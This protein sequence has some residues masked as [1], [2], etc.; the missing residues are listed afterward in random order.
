MYELAWYLEMYGFHGT[1]PAPKLL[2]SPCAVKASSE[3]EKFME[4][5]HLVS[6]LPLETTS[7]LEVNLIKVP[8]SAVAALEDVTSFKDLLR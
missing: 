8:A 5:T 4:T 2:A 7:Y 3:A 1:G 6:D